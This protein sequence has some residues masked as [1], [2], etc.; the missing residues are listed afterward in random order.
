MSFI[1]FTIWFVISVILI[2]AS[3][4]S[5]M[6]LIK[7]KQAWSAFARKHGLLYEKGRF[8]SSPSI[9]G[10]IDTFRVAFFAAERQAL[11]VR[12]RRMMN[13]LEI[14]LPKGLV[15]GGAI[16]TEEMVPFMNALTTLHPF[17]PASDQWDKSLK[18]YVRNEEAVK[19]WLTDER[20]THLVG[21]IGIKNSDN[22]LIFDDEQAVVRIE[23]RDPLTDPEKMEK[24][25]M[26][27]IRHAKAL[28][29]L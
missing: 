17:V 8:L 2:G 13:A 29:A 23:T 19:A 11:D 27:V 25:V 7:Q 16:G 24:V 21:M 18:F 10:H 6:I 12:Q 1:G 5:A 20:I 14:N 9:S 15:D 3:I 22:L 28:L 26:R 4:W